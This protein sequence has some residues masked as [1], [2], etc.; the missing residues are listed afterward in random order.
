[1]GTGS[2]FTIFL[3]V[4]TAL[5]TPSESADVTVASGMNEL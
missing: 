4:E 2:R 5:R 3:P 1:L